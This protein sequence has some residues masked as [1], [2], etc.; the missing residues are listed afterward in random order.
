MEKALFVACAEGDFPK[1]KELLAQGCL[2]NGKNPKDS[3]QDSQVL[4]QPMRQ[5]LADGGLHDTNGQ[6]L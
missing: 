6:N 1:V 5:P 4:E 2:P 3:A